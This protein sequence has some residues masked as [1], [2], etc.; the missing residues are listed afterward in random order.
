MNDDISS[1]ETETREISSI[2][3]QNLEEEEEEEEKTK[4]MKVK[5]FQKSFFM[6]SISSTTNTS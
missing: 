5:R 4:L 2:D 1:S 3:V 6:K